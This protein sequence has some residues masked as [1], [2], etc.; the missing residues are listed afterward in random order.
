MKPEF[1]LVMLR[2]VMYQRRCAVLERLLI[3]YRL[4]RQP[5]ESLFKELETTGRYINHEGDWIGI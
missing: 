5:P 4:Q 3:C 1:V 2:L